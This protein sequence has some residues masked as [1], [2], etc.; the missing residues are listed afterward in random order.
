MSGI[1]Q[2]STFS[3]SRKAES[4]LNVVFLISTFLSKILMDQ[5]EIFCFIQ[6]AF[7]RFDPSRSGHV[8]TKVPF[9]TLCYMILIIVFLINLCKRVHTA[10]ANQLGLVFLFLKNLKNKNVKD[11]MTKRQYHR[12]Y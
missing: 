10:L 11:S 4:R 9:T 1:S 8:A 7:N 12:F 6:E 5:S 3:S 2:R